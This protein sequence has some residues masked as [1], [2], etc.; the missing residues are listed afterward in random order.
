[1]TYRTARLAD[2][3]YDVQDEQGTSQLEPFGGPYDTEELAEATRRML[4]ASDQVSDQ[5]AGINESLRVLAL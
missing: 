1:M 5:I 4:V 3:K 2:G